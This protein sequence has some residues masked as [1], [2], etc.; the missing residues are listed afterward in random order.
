MIPGH[1]KISVVVGI[2]GQ[3][4]IVNKQNGS[5]DIFGGSRNF[6]QNVNNPENL[7]KSGQ[8]L[9]FKKGGHLKNSVVVGISGKKLIIRKNFQ[10]P[11]EL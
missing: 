10:N 11:A 3:T 7:K 9:I 8:T 2:A 1:R 4:L 6:W 5:L